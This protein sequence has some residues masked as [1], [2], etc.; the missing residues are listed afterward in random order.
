[1]SL[2]L[3]PPELILNMLFFTPLPYALRFGQTCK[4]YNAIIQSDFYWKGCVQKY[5][6]IACQIF[7]ALPQ[8]VNWKQTYKVCY[9]SREHCFN[10]PSFTSIK[11]FA[12]LKIFF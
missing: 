5:A 6:K 1:M 2:A 4:S 3:C 10:G 9:D 11:R 7:T 8:E 12:S